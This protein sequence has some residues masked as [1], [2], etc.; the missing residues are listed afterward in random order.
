MA[1]GIDVV[2]RALGAKGVQGAALANKRL[3][4]LPNGMTYIGEVDYYADLPTT[5]VEVGYVYSVKYKGTS[6]ST[7]LSG[8]EYVWGKSGSTNQWIPVGPDDSM[9]GT[10]KSVS[11]DIGLVVS[12][13]ATVNPT[14]G[15]HSDYKL[16]TNVEWAA[17][18]DLLVNQE[19]IKS[20]N[21]NNI[22]GPGNLNIRTYQ[23]FPVGWV[24]DST[25]KVFCDSVNA[26]STATAGM[27][28]LGELT[29]TDFTTSGINIYN[30]E[31][32]VE[33]IEGTGISGKVIHLILTSGNVAPYRWEYTYWNNGINVSGWIS[34]QPKMSAGT[35]INIVND[36]INTKIPEC[37]TGTDGEF[38]LKCIV[39]SGVTTYSWVNMNDLSYEYMTVLKTNKIENVTELIIDEESTKVGVHPI[40]YGVFTDE[41][42]MLISANDL[43]YAKDG[44]SYTNLTDEMVFELGT[45]IFKL[46]D[47]N[48]VS[49]PVTIR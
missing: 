30:G 43:V 23:I 8:R 5:N 25:T 45:Y 24:T 14:I 40:V 41:S 42:I 21:G 1:T 10:V 11:A 26:D 4:K 16:P 39:A 44:G 33:I 49:D 19:N 47:Y 17:K 28:Y 48:I 13:D 31:V 46:K 9:F 2:A 38:F 34:F 22:L 29:C 15:V 6:P 27:V 3:D 20:I 37:P 18:Q 35:G 36:V 32:V 7:E 12:G